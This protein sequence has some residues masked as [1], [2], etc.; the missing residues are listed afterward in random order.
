MKRT[1]RVWLSLLGAV[2][3]LAGGGPAAATN[4][5]DPGPVDNC[6]SANCGSRIIA[7]TVLLSS[8][9][10]V[11]WVAE[12]GVRQGEC[13]RIDV[14]SQGTDLEAVL[15]APSGTVWHKNNRTS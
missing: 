6:G 9:F 2:F 1:M 8:D 12:I 14:T 7:G 15:I 11:P 4:M 3:L 13:L 10:A 5:F